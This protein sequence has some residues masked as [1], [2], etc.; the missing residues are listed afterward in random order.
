MSTQMENLVTEDWE[1]KEN[2]PLGLIGAVIGILLGS[3]LWVL[4]GQIGFI[5]GIA[6]YAI[7]FCGMKGYQLLGKKLSKTGIIICIVL[8]FLAIIGAEVVSLGITAYR[9]LSEYY[10]LTLGESFSLLPELLKEP[11]L[12]GAVAKDLAIGYILS[13]WA[14]YSSV[15][16][17]WRQTGGK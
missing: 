7:V 5:A 10:S 12:V 6:G 13:I 16:N 1:K 17:T 14:S 11:E 3:V 2:L 9:E 15:K 8:S 4:I